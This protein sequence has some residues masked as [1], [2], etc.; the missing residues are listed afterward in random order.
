MG[1]RSTVGTG[2]TDL[3]GFG[4]PLA[5]SEMRSST[6]GVIKFTLHKSSYD[7]G[8]IPISGQTFTDSGTQPVK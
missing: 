1:K 8:F 3:D 4:T 5:T 7:W 2:G 6:S